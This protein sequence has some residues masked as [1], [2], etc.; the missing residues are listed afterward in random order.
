VQV[1]EACFFLGLTTEEA[2]EALGL[3]ARTV[4]REW[5]KARMLLGALLTTP[6]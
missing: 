4:K 2:G 1:V 5:Q 3:S 6:E